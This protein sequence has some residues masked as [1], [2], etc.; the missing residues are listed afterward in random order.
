MLYLA[1]TSILLWALNQPGRL[2]S[3]IAEILQHEEALVFF[4]PISIWEIAIK[5]GLGK[6]DLRGHEPEEFLA[7]LERS[8]FVAKT[9]EPSTLAS[10]HRLPRY[11]KDPFDRLLIWDAITNGLILL[12]ADKACDLYIPE[13]LRVIH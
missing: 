12:S 1:D 8:F 2:S 11:H 13:G 9:V 5:Y 10:V 6:L 3:E 7:E 4:S